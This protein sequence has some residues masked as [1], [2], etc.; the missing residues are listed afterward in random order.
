MTEIKER[1]AHELEEA[2]ELLHE[3]TE[4]LF[5]TCWALEDCL[6]ELVRLGHEHKQDE[7]HLLC[8]ESLAWFQEEFARREVRADAQHEKYA[9]AMREKRRNRLRLV[10]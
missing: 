8:K 4:M 10:K 3:R 1:H 9:A 5:D 7:L 2:E 6:N